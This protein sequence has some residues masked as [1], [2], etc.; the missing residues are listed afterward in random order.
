ML[1][2]SGTRNKSGQPLAQF[3]DGAFKLAIETRLPILPVTVVGTA[4]LLSPFKAVQLSPGNIQC[5]IDKAIDVGINDD[6]EL[7]KEKVRNT[8]LQ[9]LN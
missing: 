1:F 2:R 3:Y 8:M 6:V 5:Y 4:K 9:H 7:L